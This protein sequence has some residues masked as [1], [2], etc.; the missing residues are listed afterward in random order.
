MHPENLQALIQH[1]VLEVLNACGGNKSQTAM[2][3]GISRSSLYRLLD[4]ARDQPH[5]EPDPTSATRH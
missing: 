4:M 2:R 3:L 1:H 5:P